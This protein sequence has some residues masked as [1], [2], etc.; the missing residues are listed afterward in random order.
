MSE[1]KI[2]V[3]NKNVSSD[4]RFMDFSPC[5]CDKN[6]EIRL[7]AIMDGGAI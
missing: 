6:R 3:L 1:W 5:K 7:T 2:M 4:W